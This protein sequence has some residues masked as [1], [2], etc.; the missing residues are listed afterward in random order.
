MSIIHLHLLVREYAVV[1]MFGWSGIDCGV[2]RTGLL[3]SWGTR[4]TG[5][6]VVLPEGG[7][8]GRSFLV[9]EGTLESHRPV[10]VSGPCNSYSL[11]WRWQWF[12]GTSS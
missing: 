10:P 3:Q 11:D 6:G 12:Y 5:Q 4:K 7:W 9:H 2:G 1:V 8:G